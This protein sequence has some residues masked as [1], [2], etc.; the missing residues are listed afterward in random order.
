MGFSKQ[1]ESLP[2]KL[3]VISYS[4]LALFQLPAGVNSAAVDALLFIKIHEKPQNL[5]V[6]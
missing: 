4:A 6:E 1:W 5:R 2:P 3:N